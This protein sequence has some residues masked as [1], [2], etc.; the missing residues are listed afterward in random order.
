MYVILSNDCAYPICITNLN[1][2]EKLS[3]GMLFGNKTLGEFPLKLALY[4][5]NLELKILVK[6]VY[7]IFS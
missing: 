6:D 7:V 4:E 1:M 5:M 2:K 3:I